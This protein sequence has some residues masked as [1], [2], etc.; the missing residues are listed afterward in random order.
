MT[1]E[2][3]SLVEENL[4]L[5][6]FIIARHYKNTRELGD[7]DDVVQIGCVGLCKAAATYNPES[8]HRFS[9]Y[10]G[11]CIRNEIK[12][13]LRECKAVMRSGDRHRV[14]LDTQNGDDFSLLELLADPNSDIENIATLREIYL[15]LANAFKDEPVLFEVATGQMTQQE[16]ADLLGVTQPVISRRIKSI[17][18]QYTERENPHGENQHGSGSY[19]A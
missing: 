13:A 15:S 16:P 8:G 19:L 17:I 2:Q 6:L 12:M 10:A 18:Q 14:S 11:R 3:K 1:D 4:P 9:T 5:V 7:F